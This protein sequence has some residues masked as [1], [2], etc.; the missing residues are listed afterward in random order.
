MSLRKLIREIPNLGRRI[1]SALHEPS[2]NVDRSSVYSDLD[3]QGVGKGLFSSPRYYPW[4]LLPRLHARFEES[5][6]QTVHVEN[7][8]ASY[9]IETISIRQES[10]AKDHT[11]VDDI[12]C[13]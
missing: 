12:V 13:H 10:N 7:E 9:E 2:G 3:S 4:A 11:A 8:P 5:Y 6:L 1:E